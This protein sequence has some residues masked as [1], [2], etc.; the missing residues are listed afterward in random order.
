M[1]LMTKIS[2]VKY[3]EIMA[4]N[5]F[6]CLTMSRYTIRSYLASKFD[7]KKLLVIMAELNESYETKSLNVFLTR[8]IKVRKE[9]I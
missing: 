6:S 7:E 8:S 9:K 3:E 4:K 5:S 2:N 1:V